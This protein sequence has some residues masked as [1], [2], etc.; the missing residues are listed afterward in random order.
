[1]FY[2]FVFVMAVLGYLYIVDIERYRLMRDRGVSALNSTV[3]LL[4]AEVVTKGQQAIEYIR[5]T[6][7]VAVVKLQVLVNQTST[8]LKTNPVL[9]DH[10]TNINEISAIIGER[11]AEYMRT[12][13][14][15]IPIYYDTAK[16][17]LF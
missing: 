15:Q 6:V 12:V 2:A 4:P 9:K 10:W 13:Y 16:N 1:M 3:S 11:L 8:A 14:K 5:P 17:K 7:E